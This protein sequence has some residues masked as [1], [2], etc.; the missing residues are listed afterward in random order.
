[1]RL[2]PTSDRPAVRSLGPLALAILLGV[3]VGFVAAG[4]RETIEITARVFRKAFGA[5]PL[6][7]GFLMPVAG[8]GA[9]VLF[10]AA[11]RARVGEYVPAIIESSIRSRFIRVK[12]AV[13]CF[14]TSVLTLG[15]GGSAGPEGPMAFVGAAAGSLVGRGA[16]SDPHHRRILLAAGAAA[17]IGAVFNAPLAG[18]LFGLE[19]ILLN[20]L[21][22]S[23]VTPVLLS[24]A[25]A[26][27]VTR[28]L[29]GD[30]PAF[31]VPPFVL[32]NPLELFTY[33]V[34]GVA[35]GLASSLFCRAMAAVREV[36]ERLP[37]PRLHPL[38]GA[39]GVGLILLAVPQAGGFGHDVIDD[40]LRVEFALPVMALI[41]LAKIVAT[42]FTLQSGNSGGIFAPSLLIGASLGA[43]VG[44]IQQGLIPG[45]G[46]Q[47]AYATVGMAAVLAGT[48]HAPLTAV[49]LIFEL[50]RDYSVMLPLMTATVLSTA[51][52]FGTGSDS[53]YIAPLARWRI[54]Y[55]RNRDLG[56]MAEVKAGDLM[57]R[58]FPAVR[59][60]DPPREALKAWRDNRDPRIVCLGPDGTLAGFLSRDM[61]HLVGVAPLSELVRPFRRTVGPDQPFL[62]TLEALRAGE[63]LLPVVD[64]AGKV[65]GVITH[66]IFF[67][68]YLPLLRVFSARRSGL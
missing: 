60:D 56:A 27:S 13:V 40:V 12:D 32:K 34:L 55:R 7:L 53:L 23:A 62:E 1:M 18:V 45:L 37:F 22:L 66:R 68:R 64:A 30:S 59:L 28:W 67:D 52:A 6:F 48:I 44:G 42:A 19:L 25:A 38:A 49:V 36:F 20:D 51:V 2:F 3:A 39:A 61:L 54:H 24:A 41:C 26:S 9:L 47:G 43:L 65:V 46:T 16:K 57:R 4:Y 33:A 29:S 31:H 8:A 21:T 58:R 50:T 15:S 11:L 63:D 35:A 14:V 17:G 10:L 5:L